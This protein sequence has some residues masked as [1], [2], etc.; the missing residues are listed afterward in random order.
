MKKF[1]KMIVAAAFLGLVAMP[2]SAMAGTTDNTT[3]GTATNTATYQTGLVYQNSSVDDYTEITNLNVKANDFEASLL[4]FKG[5]VG[6]FY[7][8]KSLSGGSGYHWYQTPGWWEYA[9]GGAGGGFNFENEMKGAYFNGD[10]VL[11]NL[12]IDG[13][14]NAT[15]TQ[16]W[17]HT[18]VATAIAA[19]MGSVDMTST[20]SAYP[21]SASVTGATAGSLS[22]SASLA[23][24]L[25]TQ[26]SG[27]D[28]NA[29][30][31][32]GGYASGGG[33][34]NYTGVTGTLSAAGGLNLNGQ[35][36]DL[37]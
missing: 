21:G 7:F 17:N 37:K 16:D 10:A 12:N 33:G 23:G 14:L 26:H 15:F 32:N 5:D 13:S 31:A 35:N 6:G 9:E 3:T 29:V 36:I 8:D 1:N 30:G 11:G 28:F 27:G 24:Q 2:L 19:D 20:T 4:G 18:Y 34:S 25:L 22:G